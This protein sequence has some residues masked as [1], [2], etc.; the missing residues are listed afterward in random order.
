MDG[1]FRAVGF[2]VAWEMVLLIPWQNT[3]T[4]RV[5]NTMVTS[6]MNHYQHPNLLAYVAAGLLPVLNEIRR[7]RKSRLE[8]IDEISRFRVLTTG[9]CVKAAFCANR[10][11]NPT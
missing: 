1:I 11:W 7:F 5:G 10:G 3:I 4:Y 2:S 8:S 6:T 9:H